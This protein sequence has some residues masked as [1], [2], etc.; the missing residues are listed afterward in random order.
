MYSDSYSLIQR[1]LH[2]VI[3]ILLIGL[4]S[5]GFLLGQFGFGGLKDMVGLE[6][7]NLLYKLHKSF[8]VLLLGLMSVRLCVRLVLGEPPHSEK[9][10]ALQTM[11][12][13]ATHWL[14]YLALLAMPIL[15]WLGTAAGGFPVEFFSVNLPG[16]I[17]KDKALSEQLFQL[18]A[19]VGDL[20]FILVSVHIL[21]A[22]YHW[23]IKRDHV[24]GR[25]S[26]F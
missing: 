9:L 17:A 3:A 24:M 12:S 2:W 1:L 23:R 26:L 10:P 20:I 25:M 6:A 7:T 5:A 22:I 18:H 4:M 16:F 14:L 11:V 13:H 21:A 8:G 15:G 19:L